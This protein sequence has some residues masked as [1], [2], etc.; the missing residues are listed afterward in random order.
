MVKLGFARLPD[1]ATWLSVYGIAVLTGI[2]F[3]M[4]FFIGS[5]AYPSDDVDLMA[6]TRVGVLAGSLLSAVVGYT[7]LRMCSAPADD[8]LPTP[9]AGR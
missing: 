5:L 2:G 8:Q 3:T 7:I 6:A 1:G 4:S 9:A